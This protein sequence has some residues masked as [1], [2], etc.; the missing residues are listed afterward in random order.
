MPPSNGRGVDAKQPR[1]LA[2]AAW[3][4]A[5]AHRAD[6][7]HHRAEVDLPAKEAHGR[8]RRAFSAAVTITAE[9][10]PVA[11]LLGQV[12]R[13]AARRSTIIGAMQ[14]SPARASLLP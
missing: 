10:E 1:K 6:Q 11:A 5:L 4:W 14:A 2:N 13:S 8:G 12:N 9:A 7:D 3:G